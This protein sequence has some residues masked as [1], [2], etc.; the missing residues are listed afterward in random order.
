MPA[1]I[2]AV[3]AL[4][5]GGIGVVIG[6]ATNQSSPPTSTA[7]DTPDPPVPPT[8]HGYVRSGSDLRR[9]GTP[10]A[11]RG[12]TTTAA[13]GRERHQREPAE[14]HERLFANRPKR[15][16]HACAQRFGRPPRAF[17]PES[18]LRAYWAK[19]GDASRDLRE[20]SAPG[21]VDCRTGRRNPL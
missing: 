1:V 15:G 9:A 3:A 11:V 18:V 7:P 20:V 4:V 16:R 21:T 8:R 17:S 13:A 14:L 6:V 19:Y 2:A 10:S 5:L 12:C